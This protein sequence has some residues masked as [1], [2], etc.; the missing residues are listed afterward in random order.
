MN[1]KLNFGWAGLGGYFLCVSGNGRLWR[2][3]LD[4]FGKVDIF[5]G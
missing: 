2:Y 4:V 1:E 3:I 5:Y